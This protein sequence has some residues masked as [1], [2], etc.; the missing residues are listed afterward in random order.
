MDASRRWRRRW[1]PNAQGALP[2]RVSGHFDRHAARI[3]PGEAFFAIKGDSRDGHDFVAAA[4][5]AGAGAC[6]RRAPTSARDLPTD[7]PLLVVPDVLDGLR[8]LARAARARTHGQVHRASPARSARPAPR[9]RCGSRSR[10]TAR[11][12]LRPP[13]TTITGACRCRWRAA[14]RARATRVF[15][16]GM[17]HAGEID[18]ADAGWCARMS[19]SSPRSSR[20]SGILR[21][22]RSDRR[23]QGGNLPGSSRAAPRS[24]TATIRSSRGC[25][26]RA[27]GGRGRAH[28]LVRRAREGRCAAA[29]M[30]RCSRTARP[31]RRASSAPTSPTSSARRAAIVVMQF[32][33]GAGGGGARRRR[34]RARGAGARELKPAERAAARGIELDAARRRGAADR[35]KLQRQSGLDARGA[36]AAR[37]GAESG[38]SGRR[39]AVLGDMLE[40]GRGAPRCI[41]ALPKP[42]DAPTRSISCSAA[43]R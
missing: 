33:G 36:G 23:R 11:P 28:R 3:E 1:A 37:P 30:S 35:R 32:A 20:S 17:N 34:S 12:M 15:E 39:I 16:M 8:D 2:R 27:Q 21:L 5:K 22:A 31:C 26:A 18:A 43:G 6:R 4:L 41:A 24:S 29:Q 25:R 10:A 42:V 19:R 40:L 9:R 13:P 38:R 14:R 7:A